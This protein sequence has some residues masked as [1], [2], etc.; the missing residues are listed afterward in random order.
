MHH[1]F[2][3][4]ITEIF[5][6]YMTEIVFQS[7]FFQHGNALYLGDVYDE[8][9]EEIENAPSI[10]QLNEFAQS[11]QAFLQHLESCLEQ[12]QHRAF[13]RYIQLYAHYYENPEKSGEAPLIITAI[14]Q[15]NFYIRN[16]LH[17]RISDRQTVRLAIRYDLD[18]EHG[19]E[20]KFI[21]NQLVKVAGIA[22]T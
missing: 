19:M 9:G 8:E 6:E 7:N 17:I 4:D 20:F 3:G 18:T 5:G 12:I 10:E 22:E 16:L 14:E 1:P 2:W 11:Y 21:G 15:H 13:E